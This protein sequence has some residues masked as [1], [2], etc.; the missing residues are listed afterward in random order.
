MKV[1]T[2]IYGEKWT[3]YKGERNIPICP[4]MLSCL[5]QRTHHVKHKY[6]FTSRTTNSSAVIHISQKYR[7][8]FLIFQ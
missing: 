7:F 2:E 8:Y 3:C 1:E 5:S 6:P 4:Q